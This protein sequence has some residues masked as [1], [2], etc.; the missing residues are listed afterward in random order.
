MR[1]AIRINQS[2][3]SSEVDQNSP[4][5]QLSIP[6][7]APVN[8]VAK[9]SLLVEESKPETESTPEIEETGRLELSGRKLSER[10]GVS[11]KTLKKHIESNPLGTPLELK[12]DS[13]SY[14]AMC[15]E[16]VRPRSPSKW[17][18]VPIEDSLATSND[19]VGE[20]E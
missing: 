16:S 4:E 18:L 6:I 9:S 2:T 1:E 20:N 17:I 15:F 14:R 11:P 12:I 10:S 19:F 8:E 7:P 3:A 5:A 13:K